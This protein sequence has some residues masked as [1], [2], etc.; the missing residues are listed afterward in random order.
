MSSSRQ[1]SGILPAILPAI[2][3]ELVVIILQELDLP[4]LIRCKS[5]CSGL[6]RLIDDSVILQYKIELAVAGME[7]GP[8]SSIDVSERLRRL[9]SYTKAWRG[10]A[11]APDEEE[12]AFDG[13][14][15]LCGGVLAT[16]DGDSTLMF[17]KLPG[18]AR[19]ITLREWEIEDVGFPIRDFKMDPSQDLLV[20]LEF[21]E[22]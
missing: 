15:E 17:T 8:P 19:G 6:K 20:M 16:S 5:V 7:D 4:T 22:R 3:S 13:Y 18:P 9:R 11:F 1:T 12:I 14:W 2:P 10:M 21:P